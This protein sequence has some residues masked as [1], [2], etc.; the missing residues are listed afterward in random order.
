MNQ[1]RNAFF[2]SFFTLLIPCCTTAQDNKFE[3]EIQAFEAKDKQSPPPKNPI[4]F[5]GSSSIR[6]WP[7]LQQYFP[8]KVV[9]NRGFG[10]S[11]LSDV[12]YFAD[13]VILAYKPKQVIVYAGEND[14]ASSKL[15]AQQTYENFVDLFQYVR[16][17]LPKV[18]FVF[19]A[20]KLSPSRRQY[21]PVV[22]EANQLISQFLRKQRKATFVDIR[23]SML[24][25]DGQPVP[26]LFKSDSLHMTD[27]GYQRWAPVLKPY[28]K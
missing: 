8:G 24:G 9:L 12:R 27:A 16:K 10:G 4:L 20:I 2:L 5:T 19:I 17:K 21:W 7:D 3:S 28:L 15:S 13:R 1:L 25:P 26:A 18:P 23:P 14:I 6:L 11:V 22:N